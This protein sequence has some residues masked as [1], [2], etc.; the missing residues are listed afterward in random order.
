MKSSLCLIAVL[1][2]TACGGSGSSGEL[3]ASDNPVLQ[4]QEQFLVDNAARNK[5][6]VTESGLQYEVL[7]EGEGAYPV[8][9]SVVTVHY[10]GTLVDGTEFDSSYARDQPATFAL[11]KVIAGW[12]EGLQFMR[13]GARYRFVIPAELAYGEQGAGARIDPGATLI[14]EVELLEINS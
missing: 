1:L 9:Q 11:D 2:L 14:F 4:V 10:V 7:A 8:G 6:V 13:V 5:V 12:T 3:S